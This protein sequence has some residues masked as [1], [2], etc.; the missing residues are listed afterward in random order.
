MEAA[1]TYILSITCR[2]DGHQG[3]VNDVA[4][5]A[6]GD[7]MISASDDQGVGVWVPLIRGEFQHVKAHSGPV[8]S[9]AF[10]PTQQD[11][12]MSASDDKTVKVIDRN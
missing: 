6:T 4:F 1:Y 3:A 11:Y 7:V 2:F 5:N 9:I 12:F 8:R 10:N